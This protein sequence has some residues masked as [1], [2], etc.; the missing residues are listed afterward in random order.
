MRTLKRP[1]AAACLFAVLAGAAAQENPMPFR[2]AGGIGSVAMPASFALAATWDLAL[3]REANEVIGR[4]L[5]A[6]GVRLALGPSLEI[7]RDPRR[8]QV[9][10]SFGEDPF[11]VGEMGVAAIEGLHGSTP[12]TLAVAVGPWAG[13]QPPAPDSVAGPAPVAERELRETYFPPFEAAIRRAK[14]D[15]IVAS[16][17][18][19]DSIPAHANRWLQG[20][21]RDELKFT[22]ALLAA[23]GGIADLH[24]VYGVAAT[25]VDAE[26]IARAAGLEAELQLPAVSSTSL[27]H[28]P[29]GG[30][31]IAAKVAQ[32]SIILLKNDG[33]L[34]LE[35][36]SKVAV[37]EAGRLNSVPGATL[38]K[39]LAPRAQEGLKGATH[40]VVVVGDTGTE[41][42]LKAM[43]AA[44]SA[45]LP[46]IVVYTGARVELD[47]RVADAA[48]ALV[49]AWGLDKQAPRAIADVLSGTVNPGGKLPV[50]IARNP[51]Q[52]PLFYNAKPSAR[53]GY[54]FDTSD[55]LFPFGWGLGYSAFELGAPVLSGPSMPI[56][57]SIRV[58]V[59]VRN[60]GSRAGDETVQLY[61]RDK[62]GS[63]ARP[64][65]Q[66]KGFQR[67]TLAAGEKR[68]VTFTLEASALEMWDDRMRRAVEPGEFDVMTGANSAQ[69]QTTTL[70]VLGRSDK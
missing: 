26:R 30:D 16:R 13:P 67:V 59:E 51:G 48:N 42:A 6:R 54:L 46:V 50:T 55:P 14:V 65:K 36:K 64:V 70:T 8:G 38:R 3:V 20:V 21:L 25:K 27:G 2:G 5:R 68:T 22:G 39:L 44:K 66:L 1:L 40:V 17:A 31:A 34:P 49:A 11:L 63:I 37:V 32:R 69:L 58:S 43:E 9:E 45:T 29:Q 4:E 53:R 23:P 19:V 7:A 12:A 28:L 18:D 15:A 52:L 57:G 60:A 56:D 61:V 41:A 10:H 47:A 62:I 33:A 24:K 35:A